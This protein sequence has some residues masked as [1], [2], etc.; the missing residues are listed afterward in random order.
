MSVGGISG[1]GRHRHRC[2]IGPCDS[3][4]EGAGV[5]LALV[6]GDSPVGDYLEDLALL[7]CGVGGVGGVEGVAAVGVDGQSVHR[8]LQVVGQGGTI[9]GI[10]GLELS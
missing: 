1:G 4:G 5:G 3:D 6:I 9:V 10:A 7:Q 8:S 2:V